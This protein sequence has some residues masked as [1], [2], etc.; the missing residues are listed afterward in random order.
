MTRSEASQLISLLVVLVGCACL[1]FGLGRL[2]RGRRPE[3]E[4][5]RSRMGR[6][7]AFLRDARATS[8]SKHTRLT[9]AFECIYLCCCEVA[10]ARGMRLDGLDHPDIKL[11]EFGL[12][13]LGVHEA[14]KIAVQGLAQWRAD[15][16]PFFPETSVDDACH[17]A[18]R[19]NRRAIAELT[20][21]RN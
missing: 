10:E 18:E 21:L 11:V 9:C 14:E 5:V 13:A 16:S 8:V 20:R 7:A 1:G 2:I 15:A 4:G 17:L 19:I 12:S 6:S 3:F